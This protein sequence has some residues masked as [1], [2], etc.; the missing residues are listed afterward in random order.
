MQREYRNVS[1]QI[2]Q[3]V[4]IEV[5]ERIGVGQKLLIMTAQDIPGSHLAEPNQV[6]DIQRTDMIGTSSQELLPIS[7]LPEPEALH[8]LV[9]VAH[10]GV[11]IRCP[12]QVEV[13]QLL[14]VRTHDLVRVD[15]D[16]LVEVHGEQDVEEENFVRPDDPLLLALMSQPRRPLVR[17]ELVLETV[18]LSEVRNKLLRKDS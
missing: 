8:V 6:Y 3:Q 16:D 18:F 15:E 4:L 2:V 5:S 12:L 9:I 11:A 13:D 7:R 14:Q 1:L 10:G 17:D